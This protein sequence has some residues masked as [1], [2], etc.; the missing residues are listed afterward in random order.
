MPGL[1]VSVCPTLAVPVMVGRLR[2]TGGVRAPA[3]TTAVGFELT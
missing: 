2:F 1:A 3:P